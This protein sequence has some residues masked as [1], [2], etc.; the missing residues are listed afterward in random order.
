MD[1]CGID[2]DG[3]ICDCVTC[4]QCC[5]VLMSCWLCLCGVRSVVSGH[6]FSVM[7]VLFGTFW[8]V[9]WG[10][11]CFEC[12]LCVWTKWL[13]FCVLDVAVVIAVFDCLVIVG[14]GV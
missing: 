8:C 12:F 1:V 4:F 11:I 2:V 6:R 10:W 7:L 14:A 13:V 9:C 5:C 3:R